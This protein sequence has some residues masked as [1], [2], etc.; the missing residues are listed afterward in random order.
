MRDGDT[1][2]EPVDPPPFA[3]PIQR[4]AAFTGRRLA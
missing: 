4:L 1:F 3:T 2:A